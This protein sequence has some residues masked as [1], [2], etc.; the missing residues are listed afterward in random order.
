MY[1]FYGN[2][3]VGRQI[4]YTYYRTKGPIW[5]NDLRCSGFEEDLSQCQHDGWGVHNCG[6]SEDVWISCVDEHGQLRV[7]RLFERFLIKSLYRQALLLVGSHATPPSVGT[8]FPHLY[9]LLTASLV[10]GLSS[11]LTCSV[12][13]CS[14]TKKPIP[15]V[16]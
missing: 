7:A 11:R 4:S 15:L 1:D 10:L 12:D 8:V 14:R 3:R 2:R 6:H 5:L 13:I 16:R 9:A